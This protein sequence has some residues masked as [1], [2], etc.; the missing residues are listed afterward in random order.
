VPARC[1]VQLRAKREL[2]RRPTRQ[3]HAR[4]SL[5]PAVLV[6]AGERNLGLRKVGD[7]ERGG[8]T[9]CLDRDRLQERRSLTWVVSADASGR[10]PAQLDLAR[11]EGR[12]D[13]DV[14]LE[15]ATCDI[16]CSNALAVDEDV[17]ML[18][19]PRGDLGS[20]DEIATC[21]AGEQQARFSLEPAVLVDAG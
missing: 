12:F 18:T 21:P 3:Q 13:R 10:G 20:D 2:A 5:Q 19:L 17:E 4:L 16:T 9:R 15:Q 1:G 14:Q 6:D 7:L 8:S 11:R